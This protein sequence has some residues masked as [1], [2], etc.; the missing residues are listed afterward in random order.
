MFKTEVCL[1]WLDLVD[2]ES[3]ILNSFSSLCEGLLATVEYQQSVCQ[4]G[5]QHASARVT[6]VQTLQDLGS[7]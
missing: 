7:L 6:K 2:L 1:D 4:L 3:H 5:G